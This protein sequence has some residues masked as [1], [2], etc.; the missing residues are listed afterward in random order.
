[1]LIISLS[2][3]QNLFCVN[4]FGIRAADMKGIGL[5]LSVWLLLPQFCM[6][7]WCLIVLEVSS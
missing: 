6:V 4:V 5:N 7:F 3:L 1:M 2:G